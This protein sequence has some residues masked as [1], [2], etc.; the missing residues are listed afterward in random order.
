MI[1]LSYLCSLFLFTMMFFG[2]RSDTT[3]SETVEENTSV[4]E[5][6]PTDYLYLIGKDFLLDDQHSYIGFKIKYFGFSPVRGRFD[7][8]DGTIFYDPENIPATSMEV[9]IDVKSIN[10]GNETR[11]KDLITGTAWFDASRHPYIKFR[12]T[13]LAEEANGSFSLRGNFTMNG[14]TKTLTLNFDTPTEMSRDWAF[15]EQVDFSARLTLHRKDFDVHGGDFWDSVMENGL[16][17]LSDEVEIELDLHTRRPDY[18]KRYEDLEPENIRKITVDT[19][20]SAGIEAGIS[21]IHSL[22]NKT[23]SPFTVG[24]YST[25]GQILVARDMLA[26]AEAVFKIA[27]QNNPDSVSIYNQLGIIALKTGDRENA[28][29]YFEKVLEL[30][31]SNSR[32]TAYLKNYL[33]QR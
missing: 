31:P 33:H 28:R 7:R 6:K 12:T 5:I 21:Y 1:R 22:E 11:D 26:E 10:T 27:L 16:T 2:C 8:F 25:I 14:I 18:N 19:I 30:E 13:S 4:K 17:Q 24:A 3:K 9:F 15:N 23:E 32:A 20:K 29:R